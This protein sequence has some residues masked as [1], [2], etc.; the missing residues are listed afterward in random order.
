MGEIVQHHYRQRWMG[1]RFFR[2]TAQKKYIKG[3]LNL[4]V[5]KAYLSCKILILKPPS[6]SF[7]QDTDTS[8]LV[9]RAADRIVIVEHNDSTPIMVGESLQSA[10]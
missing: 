2:I 8:L 6:S 7:W 4:S 5:K 10:K 3:R 9:S 1:G